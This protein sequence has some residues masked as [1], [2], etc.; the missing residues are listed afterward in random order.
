MLTSRAVD[1]AVLGALDED[2]PYGD[3]TSQSA[4]PAD[5]TS[6]ARLVAR[7]AGVMSGIAVFARAFTLQNDDIA[8]IPLIKDGERFEAGQA[9][10]EVHGPTVDILTAERVALNFTQRM[11]GIATMTAAFVDTVDAIYEGDVDFPVAKPRRFAKTRIVD[12][13]KTTPGLRSFEKYAV[14]CGGGHNHRYGL[15][16]AVMLKDNHLAALAAQGI[17]LSD[18]IR[19][20]RGSVGHTTHIE[21]EVDALGQIPDVLAG[22]ADTI[23][24][25]NFSL[26]DTRRGVE[27]IDG[28]AIVEASGN[29]T[30]ERVP[31][32][33]AT[34]VDVISVGALTHSVRSVDLGLDFQDS[35][36][37]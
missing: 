31:E 2:A 14:T 32:V 7:E 24:L 29:M 10:A 1:A 30:L 23:M 9:L 3:V 12:T 18:A 22:G 25:D 19:H 35:A 16:D 27:A 37:S 4:I 17:G 26:D 13:R 5:A 6:A 33:A 36:R 11:S 28:A 15:S 21:V 8:V 34:G 20:V